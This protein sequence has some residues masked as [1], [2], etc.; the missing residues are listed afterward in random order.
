[1]APLR[2]SHPVHTLEGRQL[3]SSD[4]ALTEET[5]DQIVLTNKTV[6]NQS[7]SI[8]GHGST[9]K[10][11]LEFINEYPY[12]V[13]FSDTKRIPNLMAVMSSVCQVPA[14]LDSLDYF[15]RYDFYTYHHIL[16]VFALTA[17]LS[18][19]LISSRQ[20]MIVE[21]AAGPCHDLG[22]I[23]V[24]LHILKKSSPLTREER[25]ILEHHTVAGFVLLSYYLKDKENLA[26][27][28][29][30]N[31]HERIDGSGYPCG[32]NTLDRLVEIVAVCDIFDALV[33]P[34]PYRSASYDNRTALEEITLLAEKGRISWEGVKALI[35]R[36]RKGNSHHSQVT[37]SLEKRGTPPSRSVYGVIA[38]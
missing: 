11:L 25:D 10:D 30:L 17:L 14:V 5:L 36:C 4:V 23:C 12:N 28:V 32:I 18:G 15:K 20:D 29:A 3:L 9:K 26:A 37:V 16:V 22:K 2:L 38:E 8:L 31:H 35:S 27:R 13:I 24:P 34:R 6:P 1:M 7:F 33:S 19:D 21:A